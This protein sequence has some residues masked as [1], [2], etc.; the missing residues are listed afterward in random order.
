MP[1]VDYCILVTF[2]IACLACGENND[3]PT[4]GLMPPAAQ[5][6]LSFVFGDHAA[7]GPVCPFPGSTHNI[8]GPPNSAIADPGQRE[9]DGTTGVRVGCRVAG[10]GTFEVQAN[11][12]KGNTSFT[13]TGGSV[14]VGGSGGATI[15]LAADGNQAGAPTGSPCEFAVSRSPFQVI[16]GAIW[17]EF[18]C[19]VVVS[20]QNNVVCSARGEFVF[21]NC[22]E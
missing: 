17:A 10:T 4:A 15:E 16:A 20:T 8:G 5:A 11:A 6:S 22:E 7:G 2:P 1:R 12:A 21:E 14:T 3:A 13:L 9:V 19:P 18:E